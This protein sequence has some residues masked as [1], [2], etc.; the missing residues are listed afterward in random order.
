[1]GQQPAGFFVTD[2]RLRQWN[3]LEAAFVGDAVECNPVGMAGPKGDFGWR[4]EKITGPGKFGAV[5]GG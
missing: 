5:D 3:P 2:D 4:V 1:V